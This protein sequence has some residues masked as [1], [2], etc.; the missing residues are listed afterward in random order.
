MTDKKVKEGYT[1][2]VAL[3]EARIN[4]IKTRVQMI[5]RENRYASGF[6]VGIIKGFM[7]GIIISTALFG[8]I[9][10]YFFT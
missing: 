9:F 7:I 3:I 2:E 6:T 5:A 8:L 4:D 1:A 10:H